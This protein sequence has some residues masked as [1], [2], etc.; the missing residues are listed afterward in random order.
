VR[1]LADTVAVIR[2]FAKAGK[3][4][5]TAKQ[6]LQDADNGRNTI[7]ISIVSMIEILYL[8]ER[9]RIPLDLKEVKNPGPEDQALAIPGGDLLYWQSMIY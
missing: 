4:G 6:I 9:N 3:I 1:Y 2:H 8:S 5:K 7:L